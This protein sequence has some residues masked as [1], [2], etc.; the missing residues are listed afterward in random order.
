ML[1]R[2]HVSIVISL[3]SMTMSKSASIQRA[4]WSCVRALARFSSCV[5]QCIHRQLM[6]YREVIN[7]PEGSSCC[8]KAEQTANTSRRLTDRVFDN[9]DR[10]EASDSTFFV[11]LKPKQAGFINVF[12]PMCKLSIDPLSN[13]NQTIVISMV[14]LSLPSITNVR[15]VVR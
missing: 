6:L 10:S 4:T 15:S 2:T 1:K 7:A 11:A 5:S 9:N 14:T 12:C 13:Y 8:K 3:K